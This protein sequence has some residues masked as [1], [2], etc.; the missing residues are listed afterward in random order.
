MYQ[1]DK[2]SWSSVH[3]HERTHLI[4]TCGSSFLKRRFSYSRLKLQSNLKGYCESNYFGI[5][6]SSHFFFILELYPSS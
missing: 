2:L 4:Q 3:K 1:I 6:F 5:V